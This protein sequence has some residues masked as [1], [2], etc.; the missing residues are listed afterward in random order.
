M[1]KALL[2]GYLGRD[3][4]VKYSQQGIAIAHF[5]VA[6]TERWKEKDGEPQEHTE[7]FAVKTFG[8]QASICIKAPASISKAER[9]Q[10]PGRTNRRV[11]SNTETSC[12]ST[13]SSSWLKSQRERTR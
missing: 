4:E 10:S 12:M 7:W 3:P 13:G 9:G 2:I 11:P 1:Q 8:R 6:T 5:S